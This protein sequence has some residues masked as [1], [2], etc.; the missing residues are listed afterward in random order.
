MPAEPRENSRLPHGT[1]TFLFTDIEGSTLLWEA[2]P[3][4]MR[5][6][7]AHHDRLL[8]EIV[9]GARG[10]VFKTVGD[11]V[12]AVFAHPRD[13]VAAA[14]TAQHALLAT[15]W[16]TDPPLRVRMAVHT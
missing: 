5:A 16:P 7:L 10:S 14:V 8:R 9:A 15:Q 6:A 12:C 1:L 3:D 2:Q 11:A 4:A 13:A